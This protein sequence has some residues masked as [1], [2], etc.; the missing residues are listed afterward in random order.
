[1]ATNL[2]KALPY[3]DGTGLV[4]GPSVVSSQFAGNS[5][6]DANKPD[7]LSAAGTGLAQNIIDSLAAHGP[8][9]L[10]NGY[11]PAIF[12]LTTWSLPPND[13]TVALTAQTTATGIWTLVPITA[14]K[15]FTSLAVNVSVAGSTL[16]AASNF[17]QVFSL[18]GTSLG[19]TADQSTNWATAGYYNVA[20]TA[21]A[22]GSLALS[23]AANPYVLVVATA[24]ASTTPRFLGSTV[25]VG[26]SAFTLAAGLTTTY[27][28]TTFSGKYAAFVAGG[29]NATL[30]TFTAADACNFWVGLN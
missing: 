8:L 28:I 29:A 2:T 10:T 16:T 30:A 11:P 7:T 25:A 1:M 22:T 9:L 20:L 19:Y 3:V 5:Y 21:T 6:L 18:A 17:V 12:N 15:T 23:P 24:K 4:P 14:A 13:A 26:G 27:T